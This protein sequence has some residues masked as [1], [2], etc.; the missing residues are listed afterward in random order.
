MG[1]ERGLTSQTA[2]PIQQSV[3]PAPLRRRP[4]T[5]RRRTI[6]I[7]GAT[8]LGLLIALYILLRIFLLGSF[9]ELEEQWVQTNVERGL[10]ALRADLDAL[11]QLA[12]DYAGWDDTY[13]FVFDRNEKYIESNLVDE[14]FENTRVNLILISDASGRIV[15]SKAYDLQNQHAIPV[16]D[17]FYRLGASDPLLNH[18]DPR[19]SSAGLL[20]LPEGPMLIAARP[21]LTSE[22][23]G[24]SRGTFMMGRFLNDVEVARLAETTQLSISLHALHGELEPDLALA[25]EKLLQQA[26]RFVLP[27]DRRSISGY[28][29]LDDVY[30]HPV[31]LLRVEMPREIYRQGQAALLYAMLAV[32]AAGL[33]FGIVILVLLETFI[34]SRLGRLSAD[35][36]KIGV[37]SDLSTRVS[38][39]GDDEL[40]RLASA[41]NET[42]DALERSQIERQRMEEELLKAKKLE[43]ISIL[44]GGIA[45][46]FNNMLMVVLGNISL[47]KL[48]VAVDSELYQ[49]LSEAEQSILRA[50]ELTHQLL[51]FSKGGIPIKRTISIA[52]LL[53]ETASLIVSGSHVRCEFSLPDD[54]W[55]VDVDEGQMR[56]VIGNLVLNAQQAMPGGGVIKI[57]AEN[58]SGGAQTGSGEHMQRA[59]RIAIEDQGTG[60]EIEDQDRIFDPYF[61]TKPKASGLGLALCY[62]IIKRHDGDIRVEST[63]GAGATFFITLPASP[64]AAPPQAVQPISSLD[65]DRSRPENKGRILIMDD[66]DAIREV[67]GRMLRRKGYEVVFARDGAEAITCYRQASEAQQPFDLVVMDLTIPGGMGGKDAIK[68]LREIDPQI[69]AIVSSGYSN[70]PVMADFQRYGFRGC[71]IKPY[72]VHELERVLQESI[73]N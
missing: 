13:T 34:L 24:P 3:N 10:G 65:V 67:L 18:D 61:T 41:I 53:R 48:D 57:W 36:N 20:L 44:A 54:L 26:G 69:R 58:L 17:F 68:I 30:G 22:K 59:V 7:I 72:D 46:D 27:L 35:V 19:S 62:S 73:L 40:G 70:D 33:I 15:Y 63:P 45:H 51:T 66:E 52:D 6:I 32:L 4:V 56:Q 16:P 2:S 37:S 47:A 25:R 49:L 71:V 1:S 12:M 55:P 31:L 11:D 39:S 23:Q 64:V 43:S 28:A 42:L 50:K 60:I 9:M 29:L 21:I 14:T 5:L 8:L 38:V